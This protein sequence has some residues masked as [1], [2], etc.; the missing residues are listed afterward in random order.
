MEKIIFRVTVVLVLL[1]SFLVLGCKEKQEQESALAQDKGIVTLAAARHLAP[2]K[3]DAYYCSKI[4]FV[5]EPLI[6]RTNEGMPAPCLA[7]SWEMRDS[8]REW[9]FHL[10]KNVKFHDGSPFNADAVIKNFYRMQHGIRLS[11]Y[12]YLDKDVFYPKMKKY[13]KLDD[14]TIRLVFSEP[15]VNQLHKMVDFGSPIFA[16]SCLDES[17]DFTCVAIGTGPYKIEKNE[18][19]K[20]VV[21][22]RNDDYYGEKA[23]IKRIMIRNISN[24]DVRFSA[25]KAQEILG[26]TDMNALTSSLADQ[27]SKNSQF[28]IATNKSTIIRYLYVNGGRYPFNDV[29]MRQAVSLIIDRD[30]LVNGF[31]LGYAKATS[32]ILNYTSPYYLDLP[33]EYN[34]EK[35]KELAKKVLGEKRFPVTFLISDMDTFQ[36]GEAELLAY[37][38][39]DIGLD[40]KLLAVEGGVASKLKRKGEYD[41]AFGLQGLPNGDAYSFLSRY[42]LSTGTLNVANSLHYSNEKVEKLLEQ[43]KYSSSEE[44]KHRLFN[45]VQK[46]L[47]YDLPVIPLFNDMNIVAY[48]KRLKNYKPLIYGVDLSKIEWADEND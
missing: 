27:L 29:R 34:K 8:G 28:Q 17:G 25:L 14:Y 24:S 43:A 4:L 16:P 38:L 30:E 45:E 39:Q 23:K 40:V 19:Q 5:W 48:N 32:N 10:R 35:A 31:F 3:E 11:N 26:V 6:T 1:I 12:Y 42:A 36:K 33:Y 7:T 22:L 18:F 2:G 9:I 15:S 44:E 13:E 37:W 41:I 21:L 20:Y 47:A 46:I